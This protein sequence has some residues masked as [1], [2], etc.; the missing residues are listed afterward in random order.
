MIFTEETIYNI[1]LISII[2]IFCFIILSNILFEK[3]IETFETNMELFEELDNIK[4]IDINTM[5]TH[6][7]TGG[8]EMKKTTDNFSLH[9]F[10]ILGSKN[11][12]YSTNDNIIDV[13]LLEK[14]LRSGVRFIDIE[15]INH[16]NEPY[17]VYTGD[18]NYLKPICRNFM[19][20]SSNKVHLKDVLDVINKF[21]FNSMTRG[22]RNPLLL[23]MRI[24]T[25]EK[26]VLKRIAKYFNKHIHSSY[27]QNT[28]KIVFDE[29]NQYVEN[30]RIGKL[31]GQII[32]LSNKG[33]TGVKEFDDIVNSSLEDN[34]VRFLNTDSVQSGI[35]DTNK[36][37]INSNKFNLSV[38]YN[39]SNISHDKVFETGA[40]V[41]LFDFSKNNKNLISY[42][43]VFNN[44]GSPF[45][46]KPLEQRNI[47]HVV[48]TT[49]GKNGVQITI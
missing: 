37:D 35:D 17:V 25:Q 21:S 40:Q 19:F 36:V 41:L 38:V 5:N 46:M 14:I 32:V 24:C 30:S 39:D 43:T 29:T 22:N 33:N 12:A 31:M 49:I 18:K 3:H 23:N 20:H 47:E 13:K 26:E 48:D 1:I 6:S 28:R 2:V 16:N 34:Y 8:K 42:M 10:Y 11:S 27:I 15:I 9:N 4:N 45:I 7:K 44:V